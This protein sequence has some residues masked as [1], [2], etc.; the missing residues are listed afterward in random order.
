MTT[1]NTQL[2]EADEFGLKGVEFDA[3]WREHWQF[4]RS[5]GGECESCFAYAAWQAARAGAW[6]GIPLSERLDN[7]MH[8]AQWDKDEVA[9]LKANL[10]RDI[11]RCQAAAA[12]AVSVPAWQPI[13]TA[14]KDGLPVLVIVADATQPQAMVAHWA[15]ETW[16]CGLREDW[17]AGTR[18]PEYYG[19]VDGATHWMPL[20]AAPGF[21]APATA[22]GSQS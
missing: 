8:A 18:A 19:Y 13:E 9:F 6:T 3:R 17:D 15:A 7:L 16:R 21:Q 2:S 14:P 11:E 22:D 10:I 4:V 5:G 1:D 20:P 12:P